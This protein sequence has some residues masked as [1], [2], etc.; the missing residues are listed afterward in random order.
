M[1]QPPASQYP[2]YPV[3]YNGGY[4][5]DQV[6][7]WITQYESG[8]RNVLSGIPGSTASGYWQINNGTWADFAP[9]AGVDLSQYPTAMSAPIG[10]Q[11][12]V[13]QALFNARGIEPWATGPQVLASLDSGAQ[14]TGSAISQAA[15]DAANLG[16]PNVSIPGTQTGTSVQNTGWVAAIFDTLASLFGRSSIMILGGGLIV[17]A[18]VAA[19][20]LHR[21]LIPTPKTE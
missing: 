11:S 13:A 18:I 6:S 4:S 12:S 20:F 21:D 10:V 9:Q 17:L 15:T 2:Y 19:I 3:G 5:W 8:N 7:P 16:N 1:S 14:A